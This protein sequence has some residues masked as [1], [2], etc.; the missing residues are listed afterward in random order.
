MKKTLSA[1]KDVSSVMDETSRTKFYHLKTTLEE[2][3]EIIKTLDNDILNLLGEE[4]ETAEVIANEIEES[5]T[6]RAD[7]V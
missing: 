5:G 2:Q 7:I 6:L 4:E 3:L 1:T